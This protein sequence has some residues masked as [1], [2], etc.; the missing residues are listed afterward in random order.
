MLGLLREMCNSLTWAQKQAAPQR[1]KAL[2]TNEPERA[3]G[4][5]KDGD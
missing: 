3:R 4:K 2:A 5:K 1:Q